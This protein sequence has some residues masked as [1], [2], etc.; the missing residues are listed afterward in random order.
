MR[1]STPDILFA[2]L[3]LFGIEGKNLNWKR[4]FCQGPKCMKSVT[5]FACF[6]SALAEPLLSDIRVIR[7]VPPKLRLHGP[8]FSETGDKMRSQDENS[9]Q[10]KKG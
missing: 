8:S 9:R 10:K 4:S 3:I 6:K 7:E 1:G 5:S 2:Q